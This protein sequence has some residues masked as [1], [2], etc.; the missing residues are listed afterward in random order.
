MREALRL[1]NDRRS[2]SALLVSH[3]LRDGGRRPIRY[4]SIRCFMNDN[5]YI[6]ENV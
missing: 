2:L 6:F 4:L 3:A 5:I 1:L